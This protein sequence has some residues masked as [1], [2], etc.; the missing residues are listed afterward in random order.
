[1][2]RQPF[3]YFQAAPEKDKYLCKVLTL[4]WYLASIQL[5]KENW[6]PEL[7]SRDLVID[8]NSNYK[9]IGFMEKIFGNKGSY[10]RTAHDNS[11]KI[12][13]ANYLS[14]EVEIR[15]ILCNNYLS[16]KY[17]ITRKDMDKLH[18]LLY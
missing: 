9:N 16:G 7:I 17:K 6:P 15:N 3:G 1:M 4:I 11:Y 10:N 8:N 13:L 5:I 18:W 14:H 2:D 12:S